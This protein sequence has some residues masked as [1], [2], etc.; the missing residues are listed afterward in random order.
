M[1]YQQPCKNSR[2]AYFQT[3]IYLTLSHFIANQ[4]LLPL[5]NCILQY[6]AVVVT[7]E[8]RYIYTHSYVALLSSIADYK[9]AI[10]THAAMNTSHLVTVFVYVPTSQSLIT[11]SKCSKLSILS[12][13]FLQQYTAWPIIH[14]ACWSATKLL[15][16]IITLFYSILQFVYSNSQRQNLKASATIVL[17]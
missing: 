5:V 7:N 12:L 8:I 11:D 9:I 2:T 13:T 15:H 14:T 6:K 4:C 10:W 3:S 16:E 1:S 17:L